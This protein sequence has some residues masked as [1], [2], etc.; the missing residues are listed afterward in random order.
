MYQQDLAQDQLQ[1]SEF[2]HKQDHK[3]SLV[4]L[5]KVAVRNP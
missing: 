3:E 1:I 5:I 4:P 2:D